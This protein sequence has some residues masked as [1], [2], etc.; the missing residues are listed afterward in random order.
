VA[1]GELVNKPMEGFE[2]TPFHRII[3]WVFDTELR[4]SIGHND[5]EL[6]Q[7]GSQAL[8]L[9]PSG[10]TMT[11]DEAWRFLML[12]Q[13]FHQG[14]LNAIPN[15]SRSLI[16][17]TGGSSG[18]TEWWP[19][20]GMFPKEGPVETILYQLWCFAELDADGSWLDT[21]ELTICEFAGNALDGRRAVRFGSGG[22]LDVPDTSGLEA[23]R[24]DSRKSRG[25]LSPAT[26]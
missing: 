22:F 8:I 12:A 21:T 7:D 23:L 1:Q 17:T 13:T 24:P 11:S 10:R 18:N 9:H 14:M 25:Y 19:S 3:G 20:I 15:S 4:N 16:P 5:Y 26:R 2:G 6:T